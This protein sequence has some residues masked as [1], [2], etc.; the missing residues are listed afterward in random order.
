MVTARNTMFTFKGKAVDV[1]QVG[2]D[3]GVRYVLEGS[4]RMAGNRVR[5][6]A[7]LIESASGNHLWAER[8]DRDLDDI[9]ALQDEITQTLVDKLHSQV[10]GV[11]RERAVRKPPGSLD[12]WECYQRGQAYFFEMSKD[13]LRK[14]VS[15]YHRAIELDPRFA[16]AHAALG[17][18][19]MSRAIVG[20]SDS[21]NEDMAA[22]LIAAETALSLDQK[23]DLA[24]YV[25]GRIYSFRGDHE[26]AIDEMEIATRLNPSSCHAARGLGMTCLLSGDYERAVRWF[27]RA[28]DLSPH[29]PLLWA[30]LAGRSEARLELGD[31]EAAL[32][33]ANRA[34]RTHTYAHWPYSCRVAALANLDRVE[35]A[36]AAREELCARFPGLTIEKMLHDAAPDNPQSFAASLPALFAGLRKAG[37]PEA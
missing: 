1:K 14:A 13:S 35:A 19:R 23:D 24:H 25:L 37:M 12:A 29:D 34:I 6:S 9:F 22:A 5:I 16:T 11:E 21:A 36:I 20:L 32:V 30:I 27:D 3:L 2:A 31:L 15:L 10:E 8:Y 4:V 33:D 18:C 26:S 28:E 7:Q 17:Y